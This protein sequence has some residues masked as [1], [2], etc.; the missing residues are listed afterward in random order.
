MT[1]AAKKIGSPDLVNKLG[2]QRKNDFI[3]LWADNQNA[4]AL[5]FYFGFH[6]KPK[7]IDVV[8]H[9]INFRKPYSGKL[10][11]YRPNNN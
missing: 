9:Y 4:I 6:R 1:E 2:F 7:Y 11:I 10:F 3:H 5:L 8:W